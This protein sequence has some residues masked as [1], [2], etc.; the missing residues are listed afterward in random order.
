MT[1]VPATVTCAGGARIT[2]PVAKGELPTYDDVEWDRPSIIL[3]LRELQDRQIAEGWS[4]ELIVGRDR[5]GHPR[6][7]F[8]PDR[9]LIGSGAPPTSGGRRTRP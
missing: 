3:Q 8:R 4:D 5:Q 9:T 1:S 6:L 7:T 2:R